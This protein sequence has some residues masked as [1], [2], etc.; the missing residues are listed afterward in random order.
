MYLPKEIEKFIVNMK[1][2]KDNQGMSK[3]N[4]YMFY[5]NYN[6]Y[7]LKIGQRSEETVREREMYKWLNCKLPVPR[8]VCACFEDNMDYLL[9]EKAKGLMLESEC[10]RNNPEQLVRLS[11][12]GIKL[13]QGVTI[14]ECPFDTSIECKLKKAKNEI[15]NGL[16]VNV[17]RNKYTVGMKSAQDIY[18]YLVSNIPKEDKVFIHGDYCFN[19]YFADNNHISGFIDLGQTGVGDKYQDIALCVR[20]LLDF[21]KKYTELFF[22]YLDMKPDYEKIRYYILLDELF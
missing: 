21:D 16:V 15:D 3:S 17:D 4:V 6:T 5:D 13:L 20:E 19:N 14:E 9:I 8:I 18:E 2:I 1:C 12:E 7:Y 10:Y 11:A 22:R